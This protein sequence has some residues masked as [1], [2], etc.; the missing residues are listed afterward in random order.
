M[1]VN[2]QIGTLW[3][4]T[5]EEEDRYD[6]MMVANIELKEA[7][8]NEDPNYTYL[9]QRA[10]KEIMPGQKSEKYQRTYQEFLATKADPLEKFSYRYYHEWPAMKFMLGVLAGYLVLRELPIRNFYARST[11]MAFWAMGML[12]TFQ[13]RGL[14]RAP[15]VNFVLKYHVDYL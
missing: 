4:E 2:K 3:F 6:E 5:A 1:P 11:I 13:F 7:L 12:D 8:D 14:T 15:R 9:S 10:R